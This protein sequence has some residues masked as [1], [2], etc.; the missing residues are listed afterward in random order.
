M[1]PFD[2]PPSGDLTTKISTQVDGQLPDF[3]QSDH[4]IFSKFL[5]S[6][7]EYLES[8][9]LRVKVN[10]DNLILELETESN[11]LA[12]DGSKVVLESGAGT[13]GKF[14][15]GETITGAT[16]K[17][18]AKILVD[19]LGNTTPRL[20][21]TSQQKFITGE[22]VTGGTSNASAV[23]TRYRGNPVQ[24]IQQLLDYAD[25]DNTIYDFLDNFRDEFM[26]AIPK[27]LAAGVDQRN[28]IKNIRELYRAKGTSEGHKIFM[29]MLLGEDP[30]LLYP[31]QYMMR[32]SAGN[33][34][35]RPIMRVA[36]G[37]NV[38]ADEVVGQTITGQTSQAT[39]VIVSA[40]V[41]AEGATA[42]IEF[43]LNP[44]SLSTLET[45]QTGEELKAISTSQDIPMTFTLKS[46]VS[47]GLVS[48][49]GA[50]YPLEN[51]I[52]FDTNANIGNGLATA[53]VSSIAYG[54]VGDIAID[55][56]G[57]LYEVGD[58]LVFTTTDS[59]TATAIGFVS[60]IDGALVLDGTS[61]YQSEA[62]DFLVI[63][64]ATTQSLVGFQVELEK[65][66]TGNARESLLLNGTDASSTN[67]GHNIDMEVSLIQRTNDK[68]GTGADRF[69]IEA[70]TDPS[71]VIARVF[72]Q[73]GGAGYLTIPIVT[74]TS[75]SGTGQNLIAT[76]DSIGAVEEVTIS[77]QGFNYSSAPNME[78]RANFTLADVSGTFELG[79]TLTTHTGTVVSFDS[80]SQLLS[81]SFEDVVRKTLE[82][83]DNESI[84]LEDSW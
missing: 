81:T 15:T 1:A 78:F 68:Y 14:I 53:K 59:N 40:S 51:P 44:N 46:I 8:G 33:W 69:A 79:N 13:D 54:S 57:T 26:N 48:S 32:A 56:G 27:T 19:D 52:S 70:G 11:V 2:N 47:Q 84:A 10:I 37:V 22:T 23:I 30:E 5:K 29:R 35:N 82:T 43:E 25:T 80:S 83:S 18:T 66:T 77:N 41:F 34:N 49:G 31:N 67:A 28:L 38:I 60:I 50:L 71:G 24:N 64:D 72:L 17:S 74:V 58:P 63:E 75:Q 4:P 42:I 55:A 39:G 76:T 3:I 12:P 73:D 62:G 65:A 61:D 6:Y 36:P 9:E 45:F 20:F 7:Y 21:I 16:S